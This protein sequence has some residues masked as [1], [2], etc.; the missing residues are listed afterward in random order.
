[1]P[2][3]SGNDNICPCNRCLA[4]GEV[5]EGLPW[6]GQE[7]LRASMAPVHAACP[8]FCLEEVSALWWVCVEAPMGP[9]PDVVALQI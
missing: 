1:M 3:Q 9:M 7:C 8:Y 4:Q 6:A 2:Q 5:S